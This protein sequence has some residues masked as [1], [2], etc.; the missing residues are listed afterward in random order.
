[1]DETS[2]AAAVIM[3][4]ARAAGSAYFATPCEVFQHGAG[5]VPA[6]QVPERQRTD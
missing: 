1:M 3:V 6:S 4:Y 2:V 5:P